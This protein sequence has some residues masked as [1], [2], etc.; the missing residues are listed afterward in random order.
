LEINVEQGPPAANLVDAARNR[1]SALQETTQ[2][3]AMRWKRLY[4]VALITWIM[5]GSAGLMVAWLGVALGL[6][7]F[8]T[9]ALSFVGFTF[10]Q[11]IVTIVATLGM[12]MLTVTLISNPPHP[13]CYL[14]APL[15][16]FLFA[17]TVTYWFRLSKTEE[18]QAH[19]T[20]L[21]PLTAEETPD[22][23][24]AAVAW[25]KRNATV[26]AY[27]AQVLKQGRAL[28][29]HE[30]KVL[31]HWFSANKERQSAEQAYA[32][33]WSRIRPTHLGEQMPVEID[34]LASTY[35][36]LRNKAL[37]TLEFV[38]NSRKL[39][40]PVVCGIK[41]KSESEQILW[42]MMLLL[43]AAG[44]HLEGGVDDAALEQLVSNA[45]GSLHNDAINLL[46]SSRGNTLH[47]QQIS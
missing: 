22:E 6:A 12:L 44:I 8:A 1:Y 46:Q 37:S 3:S 32:S 23:C 33:L 42:A 38:R 40:F 47:F 16:I 14:L 18:I 24:R 10:R 4:F 13:V 43:N 21:S 45:E 27:H 29:R 2:L 11:G 34:R 35:E 36:Q 26:S 5:I 31:G 7:L 19:L 41:D 9:A 25:C 39:G 17:A 20:G 15:A 28:T 30:H